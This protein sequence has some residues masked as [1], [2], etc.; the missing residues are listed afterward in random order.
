MYVSKCLKSFYSFHDLLLTEGMITYLVKSLVVWG[1][2]LNL[3]FIFSLN[4]VFISLIILF[5]KLEYIHKILWS[6]I[7]L[8]KNNITTVFS[9]FTEA[10]LQDPNFTPRLSVPNLLLAFY[11]VGEGR[12]SPLG[13]SM[14]PVSIESLWGSLWKRDEKYYYNHELCICLERINYQSLWN[15]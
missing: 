6:Q 15:M 4:Q 10:I 9:H 1:Q 7:K 12:C 5:I 13:I 3:L 14:V 8:F 11:S 2:L